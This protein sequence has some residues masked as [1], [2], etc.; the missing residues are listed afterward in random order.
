MQLVSFLYDLLTVRIFAEDL[1][2][3]SLNLRLRIFV[4]FICLVYYQTHKIFHRMIYY[5]SFLEHLSHLYDSQMYLFLLISRCLI[6][7]W[8]SKLSPTYFLN[9][10]DFSKVVVY[11]TP[12][13]FILNLNTSFCFL[14]P[15]TIISNL[16]II[17]NCH[18][19]IYF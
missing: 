18:L 16:P 3:L 19:F 12:T 8:H 17:L 4:H 11:L 5:M 1:I 14:T 13:M 9:C 7:I 6:Y 15:F 10:F 2:T